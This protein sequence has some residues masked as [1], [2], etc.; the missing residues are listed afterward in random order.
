MKTK[1]IVLLLIAA[2]LIF[3]AAPCG[4]AS[5]G[6][7]E[8]LADEILSFVE[9]ENGSGTVQALVDG[10]LSDNA[11]ATAEWYVIA[12]AQ[13]G[14]DIDFSRYVASLSEYIG[15]SGSIGATTR[16]KYALALL[17]AGV[18]SDFT[19]K[20]ADETIGA[21]G[22]M[23]KIF[24]LHLLNNGVKSAK[25]DKETLVAEILD[26]QLS[27][28]GFALTGGTGD[29]DVTAMALASLAPNLDLDG[30]SE[31]VD[32]AL[33]MISSRQLD[34]GGFVGFSGE[35]AES[36][37][38]V[39]LALSSLG[40]DCESDERF[41]KNGNTVI[42]ALAAY[43]LENGSFSHV[44]GGEYSFSATSQAYYSLIS[45]IRMKEGKTPLLV[46]D[47]AGG[48][49]YREILSKTSPEQ[50]EKSGVAP[51]KIIA[52]GALAVLLVGACVI[53]IVLKKKNAKNFIA[54]IL[55]FAVAVTL[56][57]VTDIKTP[58]E[59]YGAD[60]KKENV[61]GTVTLTIRCDTIVSKSDAPH[62]PRD[63][64]I[65][66]TS[67]LELSEGETV[68]DILTEA[69][70][71]NNISIDATSIGYVRGI[72]FIYELDFG[73][74]SGWMYYVN[75]E[76]PNVSA[77]RYALSDGDKIEWLYSCDIGNDIKK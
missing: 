30:V 2:A 39:L 74:L 66:D 48:A 12:L 76:S 54:A 17:S 38:Q 16:Q 35:N 33:S 67:T 21:L 72:G 58:G 19:E 29:I 59:Y 64:V 57:W 28:G 62:I 8:N 56:L 63:G 41:I 18:T 1:L 43:R 13:S 68:Y 25:Y 73:S 26:A 61:V 71:K 65:L 52:T 60:V 55:I 23:S 7:A 4:A 24:G 50:G 10:Y 32:K 75:D 11:G 22:I 5:V 69:A 40:I 36:A 45:F 42:D 37:A 15:K 6:K 34:G 9:K 51:Y 44:P 77:N 31:S 49:S 3:A 53:L 46:L 47:N 20:T 70:R 27:D 14:K